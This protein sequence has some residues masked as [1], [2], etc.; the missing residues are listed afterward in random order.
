M[1]SFQNAPKDAPRFQH[2]PAA[3]MHDSA[4]EMS[5]GDR[6]A[7]NVVGRT[8]TIPNWRL[9]PCAMKPLR[10]W[11][12]ALT[13]LVRY[14]ARRGM[15]KPSDSRISSPS[16]S[17]C[18]GSPGHDASLWRRNASAE[19]AVELTNTISVTQGMRVYA[20]TLA[21]V[22]RALDGDGISINTRVQHGWSARRRSAGH[23][24][25]W[26][27]KIPGEP[28]PR[29]HAGSQTHSARA[30]AIHQ[31]IPDQRSQLAMDHAVRIGRR[32]QHLR[33]T[34]A[35]LPQ[36]ARAVAG[37]PVEEFSDHHAAQG[38]PHC[39]HGP[40]VARF[41]PTRHDR[42]ARRSRGGRTTA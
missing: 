37:T 17:I 10:R 3:V 26:N 16:A 29:H 14:A 36:R 24:K 34:V 27:Q 38:L 6:P 19:I 28:H 25:I 23:T 12:Y 13:P 9:R 42:V 30:V 15:R 40:G 2:R 7:S 18:C 1:A 33:L 22:S 41:H 35:Q 39:N 32:R 21:R 11:H 31:M 8:A 4:V 5:G 20:Q